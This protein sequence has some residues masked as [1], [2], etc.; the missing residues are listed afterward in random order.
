MISSPSISELLQSTVSPPDAA[1]D[2]CSAMH[3]LRIAEADLR[4]AVDVV[5]HAR[6]PADRSRAL[7]LR[8]EAMG[9]LICALQRL[10]TAL[11]YA[12]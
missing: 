8:D 5:E 12:P 2:Y 1:N 10:R 6:A 4:F 7:H 3:A 11:R 9:E